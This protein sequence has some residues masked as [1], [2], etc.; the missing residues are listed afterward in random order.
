MIKDK[1]FKITYYSN[2]DGKHITRNGKHD[3]QSRFWTSKI[4]EALYTYFD[5]DQEGYRTAKKSWTV[6]Y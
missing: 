3:E 2:K 6:R 5:L 1:T 4:G